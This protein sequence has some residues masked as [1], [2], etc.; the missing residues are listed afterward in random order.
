M[1]LPLPVVNAF[2]EAMWRLHAAAMRPEIYA[3]RC[4]VEDLLDDT[5][6]SNWAIIAVCSDVLAD[7]IAD[8][9]PDVRKQLIGVVA[10]VLEISH[11]GTGG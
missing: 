5:H 3:L 9:P 11:L 8:A 1:T 6:A 10:D 4:R 7:V 2:P